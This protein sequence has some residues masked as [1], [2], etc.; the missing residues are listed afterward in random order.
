MKIFPVGGYVPAG[1]STVGR[2]RKQEN[3][4]FAISPVPGTALSGEAYIP[5]DRFTISGQRPRTDV[6]A[7]GLKDRYA[8]IR[9]PP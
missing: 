9:S 3:D 6:G 4:T 1:S 5:Y 7:G 8:I 2:S